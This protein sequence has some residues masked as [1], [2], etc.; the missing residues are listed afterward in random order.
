M[1]LM[2]LIF[3]ILI[4]SIA[5]AISVSAFAKAHSLSSQASLQNAS[6][7]LVS[8]AADLV[9][10]SSSREDAED[11]LAKSY[12]RAEQTSGTWS[13]FYDQD[14][15]ECKKSDAAYC[16]TIRLSGP[17]DGLL[18]AALNFYGIGNEK[19]NSSGGSVCSLTVEHAVSQ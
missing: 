17:E 5:S 3:A 16:L 10:S 13:V 14:L 8:S 2:E 4:F 11:L 9:R 12:S 18:K 6:V 19:D 15:Q 1:F 7:T